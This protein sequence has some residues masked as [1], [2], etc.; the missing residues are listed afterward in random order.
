MK[1][2]L[3]NKNFLYDSLGW[4]VFLW[5]I[6]YLLGIVFFYIFPSIIGWIIAPLGLLIMLWVLLKKI[7]STSWLYYLALGA[8]WT[9]IAIALDYFLLVKLFKPADGY[10]KADVYFYYVLTLVV[11]MIIGWWK[12]N[13][14]SN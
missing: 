7:D 2:L 3:L 14:I 6:G 10:Y 11:P 13:K 8:A 1:E 12:T 4:G 9:L 5:V